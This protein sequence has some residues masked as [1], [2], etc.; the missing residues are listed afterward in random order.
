[1]LLKDSATLFLRRQTEMGEDPYAASFDRYVLC[2]I[3]AFEKEA[4]GA[5]NREAGRLV[6]YFFPA[7]SR[8][9]RSGVGLSAFPQVRPGDYCMTGV[10]GQSFDPIEGDCRRIV[11]VERRTVGSTRTHHV[12]IEAV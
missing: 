2:S 4:A 12:V 10:Y 11:S 9:Y 7:Q 1:M 8:V 6:L 3:M 5:D